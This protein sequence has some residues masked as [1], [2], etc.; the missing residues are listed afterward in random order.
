VNI[1]PALL[2]AM[3]RDRTVRR[4]LGLL[5][6][7]LALLLVLITL[8]SMTFLFL[9]EA[10]GQQYTPVTAAYWT[11][12]TMATVGYGD[13]VFHD[14]VGRAFSILVLITGV[15]Y[16]FVIFPFVFIEA[17]YAPWIQARNEARAPQRLP[18]RVRG[19]VII[20]SADPVSFALV[21][22]LEQFN[23]SYAMLV[24]DF[25]QALKLADRGVDVLVGSLDDPHT[26]HKARLPIASLV[27]ATGES[28]TI[29]TNAVS[30]VRQL[31][32]ATP[33]FATAQSLAAKDILR[34]AGATQVMQPSELL[35]RSL[36]RRARGGEQRAH[37]VARFDGLVVAE[38][39]LPG[40]PLPGRTLAQSHLRETTGVTVVGAWQRGWFIPASPELELTEHTV[41]VLAGDSQQLERFNAAYPQPHVS[42][43]PV[44]IIGGGRV[45][46]ATAQALAE[47][48][49]D[50]RIIERDPGPALDP[51]RTV[52]GDAAQLD[53]LEQAGLN[54]APTAIITTHDDDLNIYL[55][56]YLRSLRAD[57]LIISRSMLERNLATLHRA[58]ADFVMSHASMCANAIFNMLKRSD[59]QM[60]AEGLDIFRLPVPRALAGKT[61]A[62][63]RLREE[64][65]CTAIAL[66]H[67]GRMLVNPDPALTLPGE[68][69]L[70]LIGTVDSETR[71][72]RRFP[73]SARRK[74]KRVEGGISLC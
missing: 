68:A 27:A 65:G 57:L 29:N 9:M 35:G 40:T 37:V 23:Y 71:F 39:T 20:T 6:Q 67:E 1:L 47:Q 14:D 69:E 48:G 31:S 74:R 22:K 34:L 8:Y 45:G 53:V 46:C 54:E 2:S 64:T 18:R 42:H 7:N 17:F 49:I 19:H 56:I 10:E 44:L 21:R 32:A 73:S 51:A 11:L 61:L 24:P 55:T 12:S 59:I 3:R 33:I 72:L 52:Q 50:Y 41:L 38:A 43:K 36:A 15:I 16:I 26:Y 30:T 63:S 70:I 66:Q 13:I 60:L 28:D 62:A 5:M 25:N 58:G 4:N